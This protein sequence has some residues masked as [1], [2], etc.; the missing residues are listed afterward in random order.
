MQSLK[1]VWLFFRLVSLAYVIF[2]FI[3]RSELDAYPIVIDIVIAITIQKKGERK[4]FL[5]TQTYKTDG[6]GGDWMENWMKKNVTFCLKW[7]RRLTLGVGFDWM[8]M[9]ENIYFILSPSLLFL[10]LKRDIIWDESVFFLLFG[11]KTEKLSFFLTLFSV[12]I[13]RISFVSTNLKA[14]LSSPTHLL[15]RVAKK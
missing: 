15:L 12:D 2:S 13:N 14:N 6:F 3:A 8:W 1:N 7:R 11:D 4:K 5:N 9:K 10:E